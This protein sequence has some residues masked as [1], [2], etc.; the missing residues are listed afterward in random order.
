MA[1]KQDPIRF[2]IMGCAEIAR[3]ISRAI[4]LSPNAALVAVASRSIDK[5][6]Q[7]AA[8]NKLPENV[9]LYGSYGEV[10]DDPSVDAVYVPLPTALHLQWALAAAQK[11]K[12]LLLE[13]PTALDVKVLEEMLES[14]R[15]N[16]LQFMD[17]SMWYHHP[18]TAKMKELLSDSHV[19]GRLKAIHSSSSYHPPPHFL[20]ND[21]RVKPELDALGALGDA[22]WYCIGAI[23]WSMNQKLPTTVTALP[24]TA[25]NSAGVI[26][27]C[28]ASML[29]DDEE[30]VATF[31]CSFL[32]HE[33][34]SL[35]VSA[36]NGTLNVDDFIIPYEE[37][38]AGFSYTSGAKFTDLHI[39]WTVKPQHV[40]VETKLPQE[41]LM[42]QEFSGLVRGVKYLGARP[43]TRWAE[44]SRCTQL[45][46][47][48]VKNSI[49]DGY[50]A[51]KM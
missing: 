47:D 10:L 8:R 39:G 19:F 40:R 26:L 25:K 27:T 16:G 1:E 5:A 51:I 30:T 11:G 34:M 38:A 21:V 32:A 14:C 9:K 43:D 37:T 48:A 45:V 13:K 17:G 50:K 36:S 23:L 22:G 33:T 12:H 42:I 24:D 49:D 28:S 44:T 41:A 31:F 29:W 4:L 7:F 15:R 6:S 20:E 18:R 3:K 46:M 35:A 2:G